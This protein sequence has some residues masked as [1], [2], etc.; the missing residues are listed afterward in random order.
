MEK[1]SNC[2]KKIQHEKQKCPHSHPPCFPKW[3]FLTGSLLSFQLL[4]VHTLCVTYVSFLCYEIRDE[5]QE[6]P[7]VSTEITGQMSSGHVH[8]YAYPYVAAG[9]QG[10]PFSAPSL[11]SRPCLT[12]PPLNS[13]LSPSALLLTSH[14]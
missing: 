8:A 11:N 1:H 13:Q 10:P 5:R 9:L 3:Q 6:S 4:S 7:R 14:H 12:G 2:T